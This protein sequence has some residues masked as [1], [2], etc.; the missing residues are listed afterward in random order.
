VK[1]LRILLLVLLAVLVPL[2]GAI[3]AAAVCPD[4]AP[5]FHSASGKHMHMH[6]NSAGGME[7]LHA[8]ADVEPAH[9]AH[10][11]HDSGK[12]SVCCASC[13]ASANA[14]TFAL[15]VVPLEAS[16]SKFPPLT[17]GVP[18]FVSEGQERPPRS[19]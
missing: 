1:L 6:G 3:A 2:R 5:H 14:P 10:V 15:T 11:E 7:H 12:C 17:A 19:I 9:Q 8:I 18:A 13:T 4:G 16:S